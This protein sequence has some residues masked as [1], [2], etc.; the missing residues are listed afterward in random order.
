MLV[1]WYRLGLKAPVS[2]LRVSNR[3]SAESGDEHRLTV[4]LGLAHDRSK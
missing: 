4:M 1:D 3:P 2:A